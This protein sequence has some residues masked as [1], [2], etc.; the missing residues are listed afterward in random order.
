MVGRTAG[1]E[2]FY[3]ESIFLNSWYKNAPFH[4][5]NLSDNLG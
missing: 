1:K 3:F 5:Y 4:K 2:V